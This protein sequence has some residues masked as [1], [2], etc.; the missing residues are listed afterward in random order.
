MEHELRVE[1][2]TRQPLEGG[3]GPVQVAGVHPGRQVELPGRETPL[4]D[5]GERIGQH[6][7][8]S[9]PVEQG[10]L[11]VAVTRQ[12]DRREGADAAPRR[13]GRGRR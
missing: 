4:V 9:L 7:D 2:V 10:M 11:V 13:R 12:M 6:R 8:R 1:L 3:L 5:A